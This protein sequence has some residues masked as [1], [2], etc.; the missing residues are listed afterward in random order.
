MMR[1]LSAGNE[2][3]NAIAEATLAEVR[4]AEGMDCTA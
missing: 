2:R 4:M 1:V 3:A